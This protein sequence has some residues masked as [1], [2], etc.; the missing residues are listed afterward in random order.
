MTRKRSGARG[1]A[2]AG[3][4]LAAVA[5]H[6]TGQQEDFSANP[7]DQGWAVAGDASLFRWD[8]AGGRL[9]VTWDSS[10]PNSYFHRPLPFA[11]NKADDFSFGFALELTSHQAGS[12]PEKPGTFQIAVGL[13]HLGSATAPGF[14]RGVFLQSANLVEWT[15][16]G[17]AGGLSP[18]VSPVIVPEDGRLPWGYRDSFIGLETGVRYRFTLRYTAA[19]RTLRVF[20]AVEGGPAQELSP[21][22]LPADFRDFRV[23]ALAISSYSD[24]GQDPR[25]AGSVLA[26]GWVD[27]LTWSVPEPPSPAV[28]ILGANP[29]RVA[30]PTERGWS[31]G[32]EV[33]MDLV[34][35]NPLGLPL[36]GTGG[37]VELFDARR[38]LFPLQFYRVRVRRP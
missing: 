5:G 22:I 4:L 32:L 3:W 34:N 1:A 13:I 20:L 33:S 6:A 19:D 8:A 2:V 18:S 7:L 26:T 17:G 29:G 9:G 21:V 11:L 35:W 31:Y 30:V 27:N 23:D 28:R 36:P 25:F 24:A 15:W 38:A 14:Q 37:E 16:F 10:R 12:Q